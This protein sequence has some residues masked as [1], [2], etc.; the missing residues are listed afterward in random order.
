MLKKQQTYPILPKPFTKPIIADAAF[1]PSISPN[2]VGNEPH[3]IISGPQ[4]NAPAIIII[5]EFTSIPLWDVTMNKISANALK[6]S[7][8][9]E[10]SKAL[11]LKNL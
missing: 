4:F 10:P 7:S 3:N 9:V 6:N 8:T 11:S 1:R 2:S 5:R